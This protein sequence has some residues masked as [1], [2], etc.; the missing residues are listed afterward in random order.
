M[1]EE[2]EIPYELQRLD[3]AARE[4]RQPAYLALNPTAHVP[5][6]VDDGQRIFRSLA[7]VLYLADRYGIAK[8][9]AP[10]V[11]GADR[12]AY[13]MWTTFSIVTVEKELA[14]YDRHSRR[15]PPEERVG[16]V[17]AAAKSGF[18]DAVAPVADA[19]AGQPYLVGGRFS[20]A[21][22]LMASVLDWARD[23]GLLAAHP[24]CRTMP[25]TSWRGRRRCGRAPTSLRLRMKDLRA[26]SKFSAA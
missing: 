21:D 13:L 24:G 3:A 1:L 18:A 16:P 7:I 17:A 2:L 12:G 26:W 20:A 9:L 4:N 8:G 25:G 10:A 23:L 5:T 14:I 22:L 6:L 11:D 15:L 19:L